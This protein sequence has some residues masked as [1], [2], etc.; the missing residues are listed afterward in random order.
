M[1]DYFAIATQG[2]FP[3]PTPTDSARMVFAASWG[4]LDV[5]L[6]SKRIR[7]GLMRLGLCVSLR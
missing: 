5:L 7:R 2:F 3:T 4:F 1:L 6:L